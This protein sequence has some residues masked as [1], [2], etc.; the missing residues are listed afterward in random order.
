[1]PQTGQ[2][3]FWSPDIVVRSRSHGLPQVKLH[4]AFRV[5]R[6][7]PLKEIKK[8]QPRSSFDPGGKKEIDTI[9]VPHRPTPVREVKQHWVQHRVIQFSVVCSVPSLPNSPCPLYTR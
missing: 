2:S 7:V 6:P 5:I 1:M 8:G 4:N 3:A 9:C